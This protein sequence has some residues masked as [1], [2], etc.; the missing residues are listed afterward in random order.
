MDGAR[1]SN[2]SKKLGWSVI[3]S[4][5]IYSYILWIDTI[6]QLHFYQK[7]RLYCF[8]GHDL[9]N[10]LLNFIVLTLLGHFGR[11]NITLVSLELMAFI[12]HLIVIKSK[13]CN[14]M[15]KLVFKS[16][17]SYKKQARLTAKSTWYY[18]PK[19]RC[20]FSGKSSVHFVLLPVWQLTITLWV[21]QL[22]LWFYPW[23]LF[24]MQ[25]INTPFY[26]SC[27]LQ[28]TK[29]WASENYDD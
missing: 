12:S 18:S 28:N 21:F 3:F 2:V 25:A 16:I 26:R 11:Q 24:Q 17:I 5:V 29:I 19:P 23:Y 22:F 1:K 15:M 20:I 27:G 14:L 7:M 10:Y 13:Y 4:K 9:A 6:K 8:S